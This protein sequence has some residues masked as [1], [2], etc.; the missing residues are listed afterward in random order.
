MEDPLETD[1]I[2][3]HIIVPPIFGLLAEN[4][5]QAEAVKT[6]SAC[7][8]F[9]FFLSAKAGHFR[10]PEWITFIRP[11]PGHFAQESP[12]SAV[13]FLFVSALKVV[14]YRYKVSQFF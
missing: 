3:E 13:P 14:D 1:P 8:L 12:L 11:Q 7:F 5:K 4:E 9:M 2:V 10:G 6:A